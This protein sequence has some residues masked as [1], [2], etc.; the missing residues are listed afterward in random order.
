M[1]GNKRRRTIWADPASD[2]ASQTT[3]FSIPSVRLGKVTGT[4]QDTFRQGYDQS[5]WEHYEAGAEAFCGRDVTLA[6]HRGHRKGVVH[7]QCLKKDRSSAQS[8]VKTIDQCKHPS[9]PRLLDVYNAGE[10]HFLVW[11]PV[12]FSVQHLLDIDLRLSDSD[13][14][15]II[16]PVGHLPASPVQLLTVLAGAG[17]YSISSGSRARAG[18]PEPEYHHAD[19]GR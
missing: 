11:E 19:G 13:I 12:E 18:R 14:A 2:S 3:D 9:F 10:H 7:V 15:Q 16:R 17:G 1:Y 4:A 8:R 6:R 5:P